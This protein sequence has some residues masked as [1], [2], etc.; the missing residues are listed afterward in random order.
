MTKKFTGRATFLKPN[1]VF[2]F[3]TDV[4]GRHRLP[5]ARR[6]LS[7]GALYHHAWG[8]SG[9][10]FA[11]RLFDAHQQQLSRVEIVTELNMF[12]RFVTSRPTMFFHI[13]NIEDELTG[14]GRQAFLDWLQYASCCKRIVH[15][16]KKAGALAHV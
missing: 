15:W 12:N 16:S 5:T 9:N 14:D 4:A 10:T 2:V 1:E 6:A 13:A 7:L 11:L 8:L 3:A